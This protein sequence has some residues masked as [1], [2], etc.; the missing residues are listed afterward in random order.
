MLNSLR[1]GWFLGVRQIKRS[2]IWT[3]LLIIFI[4]M[5]TFLNL[6]VVN[7]ILVGL[8]EGGNQANREQYTADVI[9]LTPAGESVIQRTSQ[10]TGLLDTLPQVDR[11]VT[12]ELVGATVEAN[13][14]TRRDPTE[15]RDTA[16]TQL[17]GIDPQR[18]DAV[19]QLSRYVVEGLYLEPGD[20]G[21]VLLGANLLRRYSANFG[22][23]FD[24]LDNIYP[25]DTVRVQFGDV[26]RELEVKGIVDSKVGEVS[27]RAFMIDK[28]LRRLSGRN[29][30]NVN[31][32]SIVASSNVADKELKSILQQSGFED[33]D[34][35]TASEAIPQF[36][37]D[38]KV[39][40]ALLGNIIG[41]IGLVVAIITIFIIVFINAITR[42]K[43]IGILKGIGIRA[44]AIEFAYV[45][46]AMFYAI[47]GAA[48]GLFVLYGI[49][50]PYIAAN[51]INF[52]FSDG[53]LSA[54]VPG[55]MI[56]LVL[57]L[58]ATAIAGYVPARMIIKK[59]TLDSILGR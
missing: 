27:I 5:L 45:I 39:A 11:Y 37:E 48:V 41:L 26:T 44:Q 29:D 38:I 57:L 12:R 40:F 32:V 4:M 50:Q 13:Y 30:Q 46:Q 58:L 31:E 52:P 9:V 43:Y 24:S 21:K 56:R 23:S 15:E 51:P 36:L 10:L 19:T 22:D 34:I 53:I 47:I 14:T 7:G 3:T 17:A 8:I 18:E 59:N 16:G 55:T 1:V 33:A 20:E 35:R 49:L 25:G 54:P 42:R 2:N 28:E 6:V